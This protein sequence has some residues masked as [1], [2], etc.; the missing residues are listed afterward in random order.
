MTYTPLRLYLSPYLW[1][2]IAASCRRRAGLLAQ[3]R[4][5]DSFCSSPLL[6][7]NY[8]M[9]RRRLTVVASILLLNHVLAKRQNVNYNKS[10]FSLGFFSLQA[11]P[12]LSAL[13]GI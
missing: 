2:S 1:G 13:L 7:F 5:V 10:V 11:L 6:G 4:P 8:L 12:M 9:L 3:L